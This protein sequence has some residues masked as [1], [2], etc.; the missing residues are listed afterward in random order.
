MIGIDMPWVVNTFCTFLV[1]LFL[2]ISNIKASCW[3]ETKYIFESTI[4]PAQYIKFNSKGR[5]VWAVTCSG[6]SPSKRIFA[7]YLY[8]LKG[9]GFLTSIA[10]SSSCFLSY[11]ASLLVPFFYNINCV[12]RSLL[13]FLCQCHI[14]G[15]DGF[16]WNENWAVGEWVLCTSILTFICF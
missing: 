8:A 10:A 9:N 1:R 14:Q 6:S 4:Y 3:K 11:T 7:R 5:N 16:I 2:P 12:H 13:V 15:R